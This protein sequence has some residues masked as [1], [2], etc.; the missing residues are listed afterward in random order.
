MKKAFLVLFFMSSSALA[1]TACEDTKA[2]K[3]YNNVLSVNT[4]NWAIEQNEKLLKH[5]EGMRPTYEINERMNSIRRDIKQSEFGRQLSFASYKKMGGKA[6]SY[7]NLERLKSPCS[8]EYSDTDIIGQGLRQMR[9][10]T[11]DPT[12]YE[13]EMISPFEFNTGSSETAYR[14]FGRDDNRNKPYDEGSGRKSNADRQGDGQSDLLKTIESG[15]SLY[16]IFKR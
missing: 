3:F 11:P 4:H 12:T 8:N 15:I 14:D 2:Y 6:N 10:M 5:Y 16:Q 7:S 13:P 1:N 9:D